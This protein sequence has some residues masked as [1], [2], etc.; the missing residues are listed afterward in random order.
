MKTKLARVGSLG[1]IVAL[2]CALICEAQTVEQ[3]ST[4]EPA[5]HG[6]VTFKPSGSMGEIE[7]GHGTRL[8]FTDY[9][10]SDG[11]WLRVL[12]LTKTGQDEAQVV[13]HQRLSHAIKVIERGDKHD[14][15]GR[16]VGQRAEILARSV[17]PAPPYH[18][19][20]WTDGPTFHEVGSSS[21][22]HVLQFERTY[23][24]LC[25]RLPTPHCQ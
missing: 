18:A 7:I 8:G 24:Y 16:V 14:A 6:N 19:V 9:K 1:T 12:Y 4:T 22:Q 15:D 17:A 2:G 5:K 3:I 23:R 25:E 13:F 11:G 21:L 20:I 10:A